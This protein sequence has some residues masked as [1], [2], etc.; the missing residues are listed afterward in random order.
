MSH[1]NWI[2][3]L[4]VTLIVTIALI[5][6]LSIRYSAE[7][8]NRQLVLEDHLASHYSISEET[9]SVDGA[10]SLK[11]YFYDLT[12]NDEPGTNYTFHVKQTSNGH[13]IEY[14]KAEGDAPLRAS[15]FDR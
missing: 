9:Y 6:F 14:K 7:I 13:D 1:R 10:L 3:I 12:F 11:G 15:T 4:R 5:A 2:T 8:K